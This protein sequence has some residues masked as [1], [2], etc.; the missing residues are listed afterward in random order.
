MKTRHRVSLNSL[1]WF[2]LD[3]NRFCLPARSL[4]LHM[5]IRTTEKER[6]EPGKKEKIAEGSSFYSAR[7]ERIPSASPSLIGR[8]SLSLELQRMRITYFLSLLS[9]LQRGRERR[10]LTPKG[11]SLRFS[12]SC[13]SLLFCHKSRH[14][15]RLYA[16]PSPLPNLEHWKRDFF[17]IAFAKP[18][19]RTWLE[20]KL[21]MRS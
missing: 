9:F 21:G 14:K 8:I 17:S 10:E 16:A 5:Q 20:V 1:S 19:C 11:G 6:K 3:P 2:P 12:F 4:P 7:I 18:I 13:L 15:W